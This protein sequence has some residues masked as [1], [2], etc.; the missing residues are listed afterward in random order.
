[1]LL[2]G[3]CAALLA[4]GLTLFRYFWKQKRPKPPG[5]EASKSL[6][7]TSRFSRYRTCAERGF[8]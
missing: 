7:V 4:I 2:I 3:Y 8:A 1:M 6:A 5:L